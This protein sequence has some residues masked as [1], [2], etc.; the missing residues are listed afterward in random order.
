MYDGTT[1]FLKPNLTRKGKRFEHGQKVLN[2]T[3]LALNFIYI[4]KY[5]L[6]LPAGF[7]TNTT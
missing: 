1:V 7:G 5:S 3:N 2:T 6:T 4:T